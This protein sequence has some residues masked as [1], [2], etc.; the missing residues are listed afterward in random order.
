MKR[1]LAAVAVLALATAP[2]RSTDDAT[3][4]APNAEPAPPFV[5]LVINQ[6]FRGERENVLG[7]LGIPRY[8][9]WST[10]KKLERDLQRAIGRSDL[11]GSLLAPTVCPGTTVQDACSA[12]RMID[13][14]QLPEAIA[15]L[16]P[17]RIV[18]IRPTTGYWKL[19]RHFFADL[20]VH[21]LDQDG[22]RVKTFSVGYID[23]HCDVFCVETS[24]AAGARELAAMF[25]YMLDVDIGYR[26]DVPAWR[27]NPRLKGFAQWSN[28]CA[29]TSEYDRIVRRYGERLWLNQAGLTL[30]SLAWRGCNIF[31]APL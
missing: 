16:K 19:S 12:V 29:D 8:R 23:W 3:A 21:V 17:S 24:Y 13:D 7:S 28:R 6:T 5:L 27:N 4:N 15:A 2:A 11:Y 20:Q 31:E 30:V 14:V 26:S 22:Q 25:R 10:L 1:S 9:G 18:L